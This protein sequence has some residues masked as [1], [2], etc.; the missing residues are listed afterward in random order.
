MNKYI[1]I[2]KKFSTFILTVIAIVWLIPILW[3]VSASFMPFENIIAVNLSLASFSLRNYQDLFFSSDFSEYFLNSLF[4]SFLG[5]IF[6]VFS[7]S[8]TAFVS[9]RNKKFDRY[10]LFWIV[11]T[12][13]IPPAVFLLP[14]YILFKTV[15]MLNECSTL[16]IV[17]FILN[18]S[19]VIWLMRSVFRQIPREMEFSAMVDGAS[20]FRAFLHTTF[21]YSFPGL[22]LV[23]I[24]TWLFIWN[25]YLISMVLTLDSNS[26][27]VSV[28]LGQS[29]SQVRVDWGRLFAIGV[30]EIL[31]VIFFIFSLTVL[32]KV[33]KFDI[34]KF[35]QNKEET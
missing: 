3:M 13:I 14:L 4:I 23:S 16:V 34:I 6:A 20:R 30:I 2:K 26:Q 18:Y 25:E 22:I 35:N 27:P 9:L 21:R 1:W 32:L 7:G 19:L 31:P 29:I 10:F 11:S 12:R 8:V 28:L 33:S 24:F 17:G 5:T 15:G